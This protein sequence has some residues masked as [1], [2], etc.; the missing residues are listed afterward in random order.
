VIG[1]ARVEVWVQHAQIGYYKGRVFTDADGQ[2]SVASLPE[3]QLMVT[4]HKPGFVQQCAVIAQVPTSG[5]VQLELTSESTLDS[6]NPPRPQSAR[7]PSL[8]G[9]VFETVN[10]VNQ[11]IAGAEFWV[12]NEAERVVATTRS[13]LQ[14]RFFLCNLPRYVWAY[15][16][17]PGFMGRFVAVDGSQST[18]V[19]IELSRL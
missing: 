17:K 16:S 15:V 11:L 14:G 18:V 13:D 9:V 4:A 6:L 2:F 5:P 12:E 10:G 1:D 8:T 7:E 3:S 19:E